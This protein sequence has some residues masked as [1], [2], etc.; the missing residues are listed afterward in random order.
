MTKARQSPQEKKPLEPNKDH[1]TGGFNSTHSFHKN[2]KQ[3]KRHAN[4]EYRRKSEQL[5]S[6]AKPDIA[7][8]D[9]PQIA[10]DLTAARFQKSCR[11]VDQRTLRKGLEEVVH[12]GL[13]RA[14]VA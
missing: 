1:F 11:S 4:R 7:A 6:Q 14:D 2:C 3:K 5:L 10:D 9:V 12:G 13:R 8:D